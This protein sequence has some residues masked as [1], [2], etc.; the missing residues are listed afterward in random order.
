MNISVNKQLNMNKNNSD[1]I[2]IG[3]GSGGLSVGLFL[4]KVGMNVIMIVKS[5]KDVGG[6]CLNDGCV[7]SK[8][9][10][11]V[12]R[13]MQAAR[14]AQSFG[15]TLNGEVDIKKAIGY[16]YARQ[17]IIRKHENAIWLTEQ[18]IHVVLGE[19]SFV[20]KHEVAVNGEHF[21]AKRIILA[22]GSKPRKLKIE[23]VEQVRYFDNENIFHINQL[24]KNLLIVGGGPIGIEMAQAMQRLGSKVTVIDEGN[25]ILIHDD[26]TVT[27]VLL[28]QLRDE[29]ITFH[30]EVSLQ[31]FS[32]VTDALL[33]KKNGEV[34]NLS[35]DA[36]FIAIGRELILE[37]LHLEKAGIEV[38]DHKIIVDNQLRTT[39]KD[40]MVC[41]D[42][43]GDLQFSHAA[44]FHGR[45]ILNNLFS[46]LSKRLNN[47]HMSWVTFTDPEIATFGLNANQLKERG[48]KY[49][50]LEKD[51][52]D[53]DRAV[54]DNYRYARTIVYISKGGFFKKEKILGGTMIAPNAGELIQE[55]I[56]ANT[57]HL[58]INSLFNKI[59]PYPVAA[60]INQQL[61]VSHKE[62]MITSGLK[63]LLRIAFKIFS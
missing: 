32:S 49:E 13:Q 16:V 23:G 29:G 62:K 2:I 7:P 20:G 61:I 5:D 44:E 51:F 6:E 48:I 43:A 34:F 10:I 12:A 39:N 1:V 8:A 45:I 47:D 50:K 9:L 41:G 17:D 58:S 60:R 21:F 59:Y 54:T 30:F 33:K 31:K 24:P 46:P 11:H 53:D 52:S 28:Q 37:P 40:V 19:A 22:T 35:F 3:A 57:S 14:E 55:L 27:S 26:T 15:I 25:G 4:A 18:G 38:K 63:K 42:V 56:L 36:V